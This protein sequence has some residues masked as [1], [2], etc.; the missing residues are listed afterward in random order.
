MIPSPV[1]LSN[2]RGVTSPFY[3]IATEPALNRVARG[4]GPPCAPLFRYAELGQ[5][6]FGEISRKGVNIKPALIKRAS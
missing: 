2:G 4:Q 6:C 1:T 5:F 3:Q